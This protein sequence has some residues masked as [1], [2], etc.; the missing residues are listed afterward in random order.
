MNKVLKTDYENAH[1]NYL[2]MCQ[3][4]EAKLIEN[5]AKK[6]MKPTIWNLWNKFNN[7]ILDDYK[8]QIKKDVSEAPLSNKVLFDVYIAEPNIKAYEIAMSTVSVIRS[9]YIELDLKGI[10]FVAKYKDMKC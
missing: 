7:K 5:Y 1:K 2:K 9:D 10:E 6:L 4:K 3:I 8:S